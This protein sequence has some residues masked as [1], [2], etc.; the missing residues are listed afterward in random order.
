MKFITFLYSTR[1]SIFTL[2][3]IMFYSAQAAL[4]QERMPVQVQPAPAGAFITWNRLLPAGVTGIVERRTG[5]SEYERIGIVTA[6]ASAAALY[7]RLQVN[8]LL[9]PAFMPVSSRLADT[10]WN[11]MQRTK[12]QEWPDSLPALFRLAFGGAFLDSTGTPGITCQYRIVAGDITA[13]SGSVLLQAPGVGH[14]QLFF[15]GAQPE[16]TRIQTQWRLRRAHLPA[17]VEVLRRRTG[18]DS[19]FVQVPVSKGIAPLLKT[20]SVLLLVTDTS[21]LQ[22][23]TYQY[24][25][26]GYD[27]LG[28]QRTA[29]DTV[30]L[31]AGDRTNVALVHRLVA[32]NAPDSSGIRLQ[33]QYTPGT[34][35]RAL[36]VLRSYNYDSGYVLI[37]SLTARDTTYLDKAV[38]PGTNYYYKI[39]AAGAM[40]RSYASARVSGIFFARRPLMPPYA[41]QVS[42]EKGRAQLSWRYYNYIDLSGFRVYRALGSSGRFEPV[43]G[44]VYPGRDTAVFSFT[45]TAAAL[46]P[47]QFYVYGIK[48]VS[49][50]YA[51]SPLSATEVFNYRGTVK[52]TAPAY[53]RSLLMD[54]QT[55]SITW[56]QQPGEAAV[57]GYHVYKKETGT[58]A[59]TRC[60]PVLVTGT[61][62]FTDT[63]AGTAAWQY[64]V[65]SVSTGND[66]S[67]FSLPVVVRAIQPRLL[68]PANVRLFVQGSQVIV[69]WDGTQVSSIKEYHIYRASGTGKAAR[70][71]SVWA[72]EDRIYT[73]K[74][75]EKGQLYYYYITSTDKEGRES[76]YSTEVRIK[77]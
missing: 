31:L 40:N 18:I 2:V 62:E 33:W 52:P 37:A 74:A 6:P 3:L 15:Q 11:Y 12:A 48:A 16:A 69:N 17:V 19:A 55:V 29:S 27:M 53:L 26:A 54:N 67:A 10:L 38:G 51:E 25:L 13:E 24:Y 1:R 64:V 22:G 14:G 45:D 36:R 41:L 49:R 5:K 56:Q 7:Q 75:V 65:Q 35:I 21:V 43:S 4:A 47:G 70:I 32:V 58:A 8:A 20:D 30:E 59:Y 34:D 77:N 46:Q 57:A 9:L 71:A 63:L 61:N 73:D 39:E 44:I 60:N 68:P 23:I 50:S 42:G 66:T 76:S 28:N 72:N